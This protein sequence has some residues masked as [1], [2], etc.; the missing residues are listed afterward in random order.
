MG[1]KPIGKTEIKKI[2]STNTKILKLKVATDAYTA[3]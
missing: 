1:D 3:S 2:Y